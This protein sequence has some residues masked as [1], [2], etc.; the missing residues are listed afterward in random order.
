MPAPPEQPV[1]GPAEP[2]V[3]T[4]A[5]VEPV[6]VFLSP[7][8]VDAA[9]FRDYAR[10]L[11]ELIG[12]SEQAAQ[13]LRRDL[14][15]ANTARAEFDRA[16]TEQMQ[17]L[18]A[19]AQVLRAI[20]AATDR[21]DASTATPPDAEPIHAP[22]LPPSAS[23]LQEIERTIHAAERRLALATRTAITEMD[24]AA[25]EHCRALDA[26]A[27]DIGAALHAVRR[28]E[29]SAG[30]ALDEAR[31]LAAGAT[32]RGRSLASLHERVAEALTR[33]EAT[34][35]PEQIQAGAATTRDLAS[36]VEQAAQVRSEIADSITAA[37]T[38]LD[39]VNARRR[40]LAG[41][42]RDAILA[43]EKA[44]AIARSTTDRAR[45]SAA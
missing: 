19:A 23:V 20:S 28:A 39:E 9:T 22:P 15:E 43:C 10:E 11:R 5:S 8:V 40:R 12:Q 32:E 7:R 35:P 24:R 17:R 16:K 29:G 21:A 2:I 6:E 33:L 27:T 14:A 1:A 4:K 37:A 3:E 41:A 38:M 26:R 34:P 18:K 25:R 36:L 42:V 13:G 30:E 31:A 45:E 44:E